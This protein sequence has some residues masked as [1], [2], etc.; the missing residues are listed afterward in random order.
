MKVLTLETMC[1]KKIGTKKF[2]GLIED[3]SLNIIS[4]MIVPEVIDMNFKNWEKLLRILETLCQ[5][6]RTY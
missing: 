6:R 1:I 4:T 3:Y 2:S 5:T